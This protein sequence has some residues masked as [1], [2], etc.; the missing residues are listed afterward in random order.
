MGLFLFSQVGKFIQL[1]STFVGGFLVA[2]VQGWLL[3]LVMLST[4]P[5]LVVA[6]AALATIV[7][8]MASKGQTAYAEAAVVV[9]QTIGSIRT[10]SKIYQHSRKNFC[11]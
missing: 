5:L 3:T 9:E 6:G 4:I 11:I 10:V 1:L 7:T 8:K 2:F